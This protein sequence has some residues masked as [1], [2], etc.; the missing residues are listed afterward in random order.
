MTVAGWSAKTV[1]E[2]KPPGAEG[3]SLGGGQRFK[4]DSQFA[5]SSCSV[6]GDAYWLCPNQSHGRR[7]CRELGQDLRGVSPARGAGGG[8]CFGAGAGTAG[9]SAAG[10]DV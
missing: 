7:F 6:A 2:L 10:F 4:E 5:R 9:V 3:V 1:C 8:D